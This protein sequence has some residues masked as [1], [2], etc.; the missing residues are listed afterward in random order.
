MKPAN[1]KPCA[2]LLI[3]L[4]VFALGAADPAPVPRSTYMVVFVDLTY[5]IA[6]DG[7]INTTAQMAAELLRALPRSSH[8][9][10]LPIDRSRE[11]KPILEFD[12]PRK[13]RTTS[14]ELA[15]KRTISLKEN[16]LRAAILERRKAYVTAGMRQESSS[17]ILRSIET[18]YGYFQ[19]PTAHGTNV[20]RELV[21]LS[22]MIEEC[23]DLKCGTQPCGS[24]SLKRGTP[25]DRSIA[26]LSKFE[27]KYSLKS[28]FLTVV[29]PPID[30][31][32]PQTPYVCAEERERFWRE[33][34]A[35]VGLGEDE[36][37]EW[38]FRPSLPDRF[39]LAGKV[40]STAPVGNHAAITMPA[41]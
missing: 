19:Q 26:A 32:V 27:P 3:G 9:V 11:A 2:A 39:K 34:L 24:M 37:K 12:I 33:A 40:G 21:Y 1:I 14:A 7:T 18:A 41:P 4:S 10:V 16:E 30:T 8:L 28:V 6:D 25:F 35:K 13:G 36:L 29:L 17:C 23:D 20:D 31:P 5:S 38:N 15:A 22:D